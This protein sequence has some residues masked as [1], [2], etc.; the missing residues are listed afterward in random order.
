MSSWVALTKRVQLQRGQSVLVLGATGCAGQLAV[1]IATY[2]G[3]ARVIAVGRDVD[4]LEHTRSIGADHTVRLTGVA[5]AD[6][7][8]VAEVASEVDIVLDYLWG[9]V[10]SVLLPTICQHRQDESRALHWVLIGSVAG[11]EIPLSAVLL[12]KRNIYILGSGQGASTTTEMFSVA[13]DII[14]AFAAGR[15]DANVRNVALADVAAWWSAPLA[16]G[17]RVVFIP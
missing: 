6:A 11:D 15:L 4:A 10:T 3:A 12:R 14:A 17:E 2:L 5:A 1:Q 7:R 8:A 9:S 13:A 16:S